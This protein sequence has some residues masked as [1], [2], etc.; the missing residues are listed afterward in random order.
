MAISAQA[1]REQSVE[2]FKSIYG[3]ESTA[4]R[5]FSE[6]V[7]IAKTTK[8][9][10][11]EV[12][13]VFNALAA[14]GFKENELEGRFGGYSDVASARGTGYG[15][16]YLTAIQKLNAQPNAMFASFQQGAMAGPGLKLAEEVL[17]KQLGISGGNIDAKLRQ[18]FRDKKISGSQALAGLEGAVSQRYDQGGTLGT[19]AKNVGMG[20]WEGLISN[21]RN[22]LSDVLTMKLAPDHPMNK[23]KDIL[24]V[25]NSL[26][27]DTNDNA[28]EFNRIVA[29]YLGDIFS[30]FDIGD[31]NAK[32]TVESVLKILDQARPKFQRAMKYFRDDIV[33]P[34]LEAFNKDGEIVA[35]INELL[36]TIATVVGKGFTAGV[37]A[38]LFGDHALGNIIRGNVNGD[39]SMKDLINNGVSLGAAVN[40]AVN[41]QVGTASSDGYG[42]IV[43][44]PTFGNVQIIQQLPQNAQVQDYEQGMTRALEGLS[45][46]PHGR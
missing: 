35:R 36:F 30:V 45:R 37:G 17:A 43:P 22:G 20:T 4:E 31:G 3:S 32:K 13:E 29:G 6:A 39:I 10:T 21:I 26:F 40:D 27:D 44:P 12:V 7:K 5:L 42:R 9:D 46:N 2:G 18:M 41:Q 28:R 14:G 1:L 24:K 15:R 23:L 11:P 8:F 34:I 25:V 16:R 33:K 19:Y 38:A